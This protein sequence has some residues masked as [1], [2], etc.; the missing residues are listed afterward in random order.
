MSGV[1]PIKKSV[2]QLGHSYARY[3]P[4]ES[5]VLKAEDG[6]KLEVNKAIL[7]KYW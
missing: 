2:T 3:R 4:I 1:A 7:S 6:V 5:V